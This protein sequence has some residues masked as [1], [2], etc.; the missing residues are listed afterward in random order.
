MPEVVE[1]DSNFIQPDEI[2]PS[3]RRTAETLRL[4]WNERRLIAR[5]TLIS[6]ILSILLAF[7]IPKRYESTTLLMPPDQQ[8]ESGVAMMAAVLGKFDG[9]GGLGADLLGLKTSG[10]LFMGVL[11]SRTVQRCV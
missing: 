8:S 6:L 2:I 9:G 4:L 10:D 7:L 11:K 1:G 5:V 3:S